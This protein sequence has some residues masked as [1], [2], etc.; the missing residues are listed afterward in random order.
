MKN[1]T[2]AAAAFA[3][4]FVALIK[5]FEAQ[6]VSDE[7]IGQI[8]ESKEFLEYCANFLNRTTSRILKHLELLNPKLSISSASFSRDKFLASKLGVKVYL[9]ENFR[10]WIVPELSETISIFTGDLASY[11]LTKNLHDPAIRAEIGKDQVFTLDE[12]LAIIFTIIS[13]Q[14]NGEVGDFENTGYANIFYVRLKS[15][16]VVTVNVRW[17]FDGRGW[18]LGSSCLGGDSWGEG[19]RVF[20]RSLPAQAG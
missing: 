3:E 17:I 19:F 5:M 8:L 11:K 1:W 13:K 12:I 16:E 7:K 9:W 20:A 10:N 6:K 2:K 15:G 4:F 18:F 14:P